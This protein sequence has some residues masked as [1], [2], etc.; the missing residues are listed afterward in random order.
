M[1]NFLE[2]LAQDLS[3]A[4]SHTKGLFMFLYFVLFCWLLVWGYDFT[5][6]TLSPLFV[7]S[8]REEHES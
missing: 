5:Q 6:N 1:Q 7:A 2:D 4:N 8:R 3:Y